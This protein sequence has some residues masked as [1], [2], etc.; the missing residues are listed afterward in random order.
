MCLTSTP[1]MSQIIIQG[2]SVLLS[3]E[4]SF[5]HHTIGTETCKLVH[6]SKSPSPIETE[7]KDQD[8]STATSDTTSK[9]KALD[10]DVQINFV[11]SA[12]SL[13]NTLLAIQSPQ[14]M[15]LVYEVQSWK[16]I[17]EKQLGRG[18]SK[19]I[20]TPDDKAIVVGDKTGDVFLYDIYSDKKETLLLGHLSMV[21]DIIM[22]DDSKY[23]ITCDRDEK[24]RVSNYPN[25]YNIE[26]YCLGHEQFVTNVQ[27][28]P[29]NKKLLISCSGDGTVRLWD[30]L[31]GNI[32]DIYK[33]N[34]KVE[35]DTSNIESQN[36]LKC[37]TSIKLNDTT[38]IVCVSI[39]KSHVVHVLLVNHENFEMINKI[40]LDYEPIHLQLSL[41][42]N[43]DSNEI[44]LWLVGQNELHAYTWDN[45]S[46]SF[47]AATNSAVLK[48]LN[49][50]SSN[51]KDL[52]VDTNTENV[53]YV[54]QKR[55]M[56]EITD[57]YARKK[58][59][60]EEKSN[61]SFKNKL[62]IN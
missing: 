20:F 60:L 29:H 31:L 37:F 49:V 2:T 39:F 40:N 25:C 34:N 58:A 21:L 30:Y 46:K 54:L 7:G 38:S 59:R 24:I 16:V 3:G 27:L 52:A 9:E 50:L 53:I 8:K 55:K 18:A 10:K 28:L 19:I 15:L 48:S 36:Q 35:S 5:I 45:T 17:Y 57:Y 26:N 56:D 13:D 62:A 11:C 33:F 42:P 14:K 1:N 32:K 6:L 44:C 41:Y 43:T 12:L 51:L 61:K 47:A 22:R 23:I 4:T